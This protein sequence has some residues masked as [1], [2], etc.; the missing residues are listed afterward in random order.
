MPNVSKGAGMLSTLCV[1]H[2]T[3]APESAQQKIP[4][5]KI[6]HDGERKRKKVLKKCSS[7]HHFPLVFF[8]SLFF[9]VH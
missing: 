5:D 7:P 8:S 3:N 1:F 9:W 6:M 2:A 4:W